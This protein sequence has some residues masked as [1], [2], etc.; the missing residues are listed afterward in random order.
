GP[1][2]T[3]CFLTLTHGSSRRW[4]LTS[5]R[6]RVN[7]FSL[8]SK[9]LR[10]TSHSASDTTLEGSTSLSSVFVSNV[11]IFILSCFVCLM[12]SVGVKKESFRTNAASPPAE[13]GQPWLASRLSYIQGTG[14]VSST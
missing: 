10:A 5:S 9:S 4:Q 2:K 14:V 7:S 3:Y 13:V 8:V 12:I 11:S 6:N 1:S